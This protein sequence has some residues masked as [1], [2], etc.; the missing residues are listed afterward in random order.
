MD[1]GNDVGQEHDAEI[2]VKNGA[3]TQ[4]NIIGNAR[5]TLNNNLRITIE[6]AAD[7]LTIGSVSNGGLISGPGALI[8]DA[9]NRGT[10][11]L[12]PG[13]NFGVNTYTGGTFVEGGILEIMEGGLP[14]HSSL[15]VTNGGT[16]NASSINCSTLLIG[17]NSNDSAASVVGTN[18]VPEPGSIL[19][20]ATMAAADL[21]YMWRRRSR[22]KGSSDL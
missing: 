4:A 6:D 1:N 11:I 16:V 20:T 9:A 12:A 10:V 18:Q 14:A 17:L 8:I 22:T 7:Q 3:E 19:M 13:N 2:I 5:L 21:L 15:S